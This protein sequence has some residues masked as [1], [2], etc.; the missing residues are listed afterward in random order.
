L[1]GAQY[2]GRCLILTPP[3]PQSLALLNAG[4]FTL[5]GHA[6]RPLQKITYEPCLALILHLNGRGNVPEPGGMWPVGEPIAWLADNSR[7]GISPTEG[8]VTIHAGPDFSQE[9]WDR[10][11][12]EICHELADAAAEWLG[13]P[14]ADYRVHRWRYSRPLWIHPEP[15][16]SLEE[17]APLVFAGD[18]F[19]GPRLEGAA[20]SGL[21]AAET[22][23]AFS[24]KLASLPD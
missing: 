8:A 24:G 17:P 4:R 14:I 7:K 20:L 23:I 18:A 9:R 13:A 19:A 11:D 2:S 6:L 5:P 1:E 15:C 21:A 22:L 3:L 12:E 16:L 10:S